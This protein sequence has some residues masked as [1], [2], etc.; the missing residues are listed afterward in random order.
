MP[1]HSERG[2]T[3][4]GEASVYVLRMEARNRRHSARTFSVSVSLAPGKNPQNGLH[5]LSSR[6]LLEFDNQRGSFRIVLVQWG[7]RTAPHFA[8]IFRIQDAGETVMKQTVGFAWLSLSLPHLLHGM[9]A[10]CSTLSLA[11]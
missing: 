1:F 11:G 5:V 6:R 7:A 3:W 2:T 8:R 4:A 9:P 10:A